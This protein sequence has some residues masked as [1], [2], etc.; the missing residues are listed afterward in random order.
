MQEFMLSGLGRATLSSSKLLLD[1]I[2]FRQEGRILGSLLEIWIETSPPYEL[3]LD[4]AWIYQK[5]ERRK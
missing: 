4:L 3:G 2:Y 1:T 5:E